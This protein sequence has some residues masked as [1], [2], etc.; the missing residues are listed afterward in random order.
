MEKQDIIEKIET[1]KEKL[2]LYL[3]LDNLMRK[4]PIYK[5]RCRPECPSYV[6]TDWNL[7]QMKIIYLEEKIAKYNS[8]L[9]N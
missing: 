6:E 5:L 8:F 2:R 4:D 7:V 9:K 3:I 1:I